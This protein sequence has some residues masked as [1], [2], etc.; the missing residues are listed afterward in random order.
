MATKTVFILLV[1]ACLLANATGT[2]DLPIKLGNE[3]LA[4]FNIGGNQIN[5]LNSFIDL[6][7]CSNEIVGLFLEK[8]TDDLSSGGC[9]SISDIMKNCL[10]STL[11]SF[12]FTTAELKLLQGH[13]EVAASPASAPL[14]GSYDPKL[15]K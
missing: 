11:A 5:C 6:T 9:G 3:D 7:F 1:L 2:R 4:I 13:C 12:G 15:I 14:D 10:P 8:H